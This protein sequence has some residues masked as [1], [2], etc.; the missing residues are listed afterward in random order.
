LIQPGIFIEWKLVHPAFAWV[1]QIVR[2]AGRTIRHSRAGGNPARQTFREADKILVLSR[3]ADFLINWIP[4]C[5]GMKMPM[6]MVCY[7]R[8]SLQLPIM[9]PDEPEK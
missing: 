4:A 2:Q 9:N 7:R 1:N 5:A 3:Y 6:I 8:I